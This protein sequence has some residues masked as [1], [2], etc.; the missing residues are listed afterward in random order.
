MFVTIGRD[1]VTP[2]AVGA[3]LVVIGWQVGGARKSRLHGPSSGEAILGQVLEAV[4]TFLLRTLLLRVLRGGRTGCGFRLRIRLRDAL[5][6]ELL[7]PVRGILLFDALDGLFEKIFPFSANDTIVESL[8]ETASRGTLSWV[9]CCNE[10]FVPFLCPKIFV[11]DRDP[12]FCIAS[13]LRFRFVC[14]NEL[15]NLGFGHMKSPARR[16][17]SDSRVQFAG[18]VGRI[19]TGDKVARV[20]E[21]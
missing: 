9:H 21:A 3:P 16:H 11:Q 17:S 15:G 18:D 2:A 10:S 6:V 20:E 13:G 8:I 12:R 5:H 14:L 7:V 19:A 1:V 4:F